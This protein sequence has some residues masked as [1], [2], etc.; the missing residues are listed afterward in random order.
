MLLVKTACCTIHTVLLNQ[1][2]VSHFF[3]RSKAYLYINS[4]ALFLFIWS[5]FMDQN[6][7]CLSYPLL[8]Q[9][10]WWLVIRRI[11]LRAAFPSTIPGGRLPVQFAK[12]GTNIL[13]KASPPTGS[14][15]IWEQRAGHSCLSF[16]QHVGQN[17]T[18]LRSLWSGYPTT[19]TWSLS[20][21]WTSCRTLKIHLLRIKLWL[22]SSSQ[23]SIAQVGNVYHVYIYNL[24]D[25]Q[26]DSW[27]LN[28][29]FC[30]HNEY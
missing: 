9:W 12:A 16:L 26:S 25:T 15:L 1:H 8:L 17:L 18:L 3:K 13:S 23:M 28:I 2:N 27:T 21:C 30:M 6:A 19:C 20:M 11:R 5:F 29:H 14:A 10:H 24:H 7:S 4:L 22:N